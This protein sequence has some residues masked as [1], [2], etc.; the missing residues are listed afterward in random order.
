MRAVRPAAALAFLLAACSSAYGPLM[1][2]GQDCLGCHDG[3]T[4][5]R[6]TVAGTWKAGAHVTV[7]D[8]AGKSFTLRG[9]EV[10]N[11]YSA[12]DLVFPLTLAVDGHPMPLAATYGGCNRC[13]A[14]GG[15]ATG[16]SATGPLMAPNQDCLACHDGK[17]ARAWTAAGTWPT[18]GATVTLRD[19]GGQSVTLTTNQ[20]GNF[21]TDAALTFPLT[22]AVDGVSMPAQVTYGGCNRC[23]ANGAN[24]AGGGTGATGP[25]MLPGQDC[26]ACHDGAQALRW[27]AAGTWGSAAGRTITLTDARGQTVSLTTNAVGNFYTSQA[28]T[29]PLTAQAGGS[30]MPQPVTY[31][32]C[33]RCHGPGGAANN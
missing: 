32:G 19:A 18:P 30:L 29:F 27:T 15:A 12:E 8:A 33:N 17:Q 21:Y 13:H 11:F 20:V 14:S 24:G 25:L 7:T 5:R 10:G 6:W 4:A 9:N 28:L 1:A 26:L 16:A 22:A 23:H 3:Q 2:P 31:G